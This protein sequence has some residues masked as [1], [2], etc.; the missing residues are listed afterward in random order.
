MSAFTQFN[1]A[2]YL[3]LPKEKKKKAPKGFKQKEMSFIQHW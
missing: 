2:P 1:K 3:F